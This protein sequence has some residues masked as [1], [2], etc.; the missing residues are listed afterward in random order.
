MNTAT[1]IRPTASPESAVHLS[2]V[3]P[4][5][6]RL[7]AIEQ[8]R[9]AKGLSRDALAERSGVS[10]RA[11]YYILAGVKVA[12]V[13]TLRR[14]ERAVDAYRPVR[15]PSADLARAA[16]RGLIVALARE[17][18]LDPESVLQAD[19]RR[20][21]G[22][23]ARVR[24]R[25]FYLMVT[26]FDLTMTAVATLAGVTKQAVSKSLRDIEDERDDGLVDAVLARVARQVGGKG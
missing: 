18:G 22:T 25:A 4:I 8:K 10:P 13:S 7:K 23:V 2:T 20:E 5:S 24:M 12:R 15:A 19:P 1:A 6:A 3:R 9:L 16:Y 11:I 26:E 14:L 21:R 17:A